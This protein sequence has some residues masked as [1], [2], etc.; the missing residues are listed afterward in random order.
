[1]YWGHGNRH[2]SAGGTMPRGII[3]RNVYDAD[4]QSPYIY[5]RH[6]VKT[7]IETQP[8]RVQGVFVSIGAEKEFEAL[9]KRHHIRCEPLAE[10]DFRNELEGAVHQGVV[11]KV[12]M[13]GLVRDYAEFMRSF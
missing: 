2:S 7:L 11:A 10:H 12:A 6:A 5:G 8:E 1:M 13:G 9:A 4:M 3:L